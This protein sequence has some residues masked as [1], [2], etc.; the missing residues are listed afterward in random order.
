MLKYFSVSGYKNFDHQIV[1]DFSDLRDYRFSTECISNGTL[2]K[3]IIYG[4]NAVGKSNFSYA[5]NNITYMRSGFAE[6]PKDDYLVNVY[7]TAK[8]AEFLYVF[9][10]ENTTVE[11]KYRLTSALEIIYEK[12]TINGDLLVEFDRHHPKELSAV[13]LKALSPS[14]VMDFEKIKSVLYYIVSNTP[15]DADH[16][17]KRTIDFVRSFRLY[18]SAEDVDFSSDISLSYIIMDDETVIEFQDFLQIAGITD[19]LV[20]LKDPSGREVLYFDTKP[21]LPFGKVASS[22]TKTLT[23]LFLLYTYAKKTK[24]PCVLLLDEF[25]ALLHY[26]LAERLVRLFLALPNA[27]V[28]FTS[29]NTSLLTN[30]YM[31]PDC[32]FIMTRNKLTA[33]PNATKMELREGHNLEKLFI[34]GEFDE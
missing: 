34:G 1:L 4:K 23:R 15:L 7:S 11:Y 28:V 27:Q 9:Q 12:V 22:G 24:E 30:R 16:P 20:V 25:D 31:R 8:Y 5:L 19:N 6:Y 2:G 10:F 3:V 18:T 13:G 17:L 21:P 14:L 29:H 32:C 26:E 33:L